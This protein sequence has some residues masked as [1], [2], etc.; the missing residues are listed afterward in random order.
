MLRERLNEGVAPMTGAAA[1][2]PDRTY[3]AGSMDSGVCLAKEVGT[4]KPTV[5]EP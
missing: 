1:P 2:C 3:P 4:T 5:G